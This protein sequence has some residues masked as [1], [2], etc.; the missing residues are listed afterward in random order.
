MRKWF[1]SV[2]LDD[3]EERERDKFLWLVFVLIKVLLCVLFIKL[4]GLIIYIVIY[5]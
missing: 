1:Y 5:L 2:D 4:R 3:D